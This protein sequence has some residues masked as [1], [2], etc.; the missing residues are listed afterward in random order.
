MRTGAR[1]T[2]PKRSKRV[3]QPLIHTKANPEMWAQ[4]G[5]ESHDTNTLLKG[6][7]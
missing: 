4:L 3:S 2:P 7:A 6:Q 1:I 5:G